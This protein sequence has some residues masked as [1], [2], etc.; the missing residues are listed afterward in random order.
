MKHQILCLLIIVSAFQAVYYFPKMPGALASHFGGQGVPNGWSSK[1][2]FFS[3]Y[4]GTLAMLSAIFF[5]IPLSFKRVRYG[6]ISLPNK[7]YW[8]APERRNQ[9]EV[10]LDTQMMR[11]GL[12]TW[13][14]MLITFELVFR[15]NLMEESRLSSSAL[16]YLLI[17]YFLYTAILAVRLIRCFYNIPEHHKRRLS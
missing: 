4:C 2:V 3:I 15:A 17:C 5:S 16:W 13:I 7:D 12:A 14:F 8:L 1:L 9:T 11:F 6:W 10:Y